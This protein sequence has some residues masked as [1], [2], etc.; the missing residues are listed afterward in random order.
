MRPLSSAQ[1][2]V[3]AFVHW[4][5]TAW[6]VLVI[7]ITALWMNCGRLH[8]E[9]NADSMVP[10]LVSLQQWTPF[11]W[12]QDRFGMLVPL[13]ARPIHH[14]LG[15]L[16]F[17]GWLTASAALLAPCL[18]ARYVSRATVS[19]AAVGALA[20]TWLFLIL[21]PK[22]QFDWLVTQ[23]YGLSIGLAVGGLLLVDRAAP[24]TTMAGIVLLLLAH[25]VSG[26]VFIFVLPL[27]VIRGTHVVWSVGLTA[28]AAAGGFA[29]QHFAVGASTSMSIVGL[30]EWPTGWVQLLRHV[31]PGLAHLA[32]AIAIAG[33]ALV[34]TIRRADE[35]SRTA[36]KVA[37]ATSAAGVCYW[38][39]IGTSRH[40]QENLYFPRYVLPAL[41]LFGVA[42]AMMLLEAVRLRRRTATALALVLMMAAAV[43]V[44]RTPSL[45]RLH[46]ELDR[47]FGA[48]T[49][50]ILATGATV[51]VGDYWT[52]WPAVFHANL[53]L[54]ERTR[55]GEIYGWTYRS[56]PTEP[57]WR[58]PRPLRVLLATRPGEEGRDLLLHSLGVPIRLVEHRP[59]IDLFLA[60][61]PTF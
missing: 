14:P 32:W 36:L 23:P 40:V 51:I 25:W 56:G 48:M 22:L 27:I 42:L 47:Q 31:R 12:A 20:N 34:G 43:T 58:T 46:R 6:L 54:Y 18:V 3:D 21:D 52:V 39:I 5:S 35:R 29:A 10:V 53:I 1:S 7:G 37:A 49:T 2:G 8:Y 61:S 33:I 45:P 41:L 38:A 4:S 60:S 19:A 16:L 17:Q 55:H 30:S 24:A 11:F 57:L 13:L 44:Y 28:A 15:N 59:T 9:Q 50:D 26:L